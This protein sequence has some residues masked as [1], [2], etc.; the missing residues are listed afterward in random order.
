MIA[1][2]R[3]A[4]VVGGAHC[5]W[6]DVKAVRALHDFELFVLVNDIGTV[7]PYRIDHWVTFHAVLLEKWTDLRRANGFSDAGKLWTGA[8][9][10]K[11]PPHLSVTKHWM[12]VGGSSGMLGTLVGL[13]HAH[14]V[15]VAGIP[16]DPALPHFNNKHGNRPWKDATKYRTAWIDHLPILRERVRSCSGWTAEQLGKPTREWLEG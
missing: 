1:K 14:K 8:T 4:L 11:I 16:L 7:W 6:D 12:K 5:V 13:D 2:S 9:T 3:T 15:V 10:S